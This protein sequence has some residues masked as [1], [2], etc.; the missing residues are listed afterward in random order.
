MIANKK[1]SN[2]INDTIREDI[3][4]T[5]AYPISSSDNYIKLDAMESPYVLP[6]EILDHVINNLRKIHLNRYP[7]TDKSKLTRI[8]KEKFNI[9]CNS[10][11]LFGNGSD[12]LIHL[13]I[14]S[15]CKPGDAVLSPSPSFVFFEMASQFNHAKFIKVDLTDDLQLDICKMI[16][17]IKYNLPKIIFLAMPNN[18]TG[19]L[20]NDSDVQSIIDIAPGLVIIDEAYYAFNKKS[21]MNRLHELQNVLILRTF[22]KIG[23]AGIRFGYLAGNPEWIKQINKIRPPYNIN[24]LTESVILSVLDKKYILDEHSNQILSNRIKLSESLREIDH[25]KSYESYGNFILVR[26]D[27]SIIAKNVFNELKS[28][29]ILVKDM[30]NSHSLLSNCLRLSVGTDSENRLLIKTILKI[31]H[32][33]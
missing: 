21:W 32:K 14:Q 8:I 31:I 28:N 17:S 6:E 1:L 11:L 10:D 4:R 24:V 30:S 23:L 27:N 3:L 29:N 33:K 20:W 26:F 5:D 7:S 12:E 13:I 25:I 9:P 2:L 18:P 22:S 19:G 16:E 15:C